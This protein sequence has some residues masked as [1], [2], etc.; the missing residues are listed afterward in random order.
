[1]ANETKSLPSPKMI[2]VRAVA[3]GVLGTGRDSRRIRM[4]TVFEVPED[5]TGSWVVP[6]DPRV[7]LKLSAKKAERQK[8]NEERFKAEQ[9]VLEKAKRSAAT[10]LGEMARG[11]GP[12]G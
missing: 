9:S 3:S 10:T 5:F 6:V 12:M 8:L 7:K 1:M 4:G 2:S 11:T